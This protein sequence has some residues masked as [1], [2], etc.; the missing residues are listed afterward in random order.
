MNLIPARYEYGA[1][2]KEESDSSHA[3]HPLIMAAMPFGITNR[4]PDSWRPI[5]F[6]EVGGG[7][8][9]SSSSHLPDPSST[10]LDFSSDQ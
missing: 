10:S 3:N 7:G 1:F 5:R 2:F 8:I 6:L 9:P 4:L